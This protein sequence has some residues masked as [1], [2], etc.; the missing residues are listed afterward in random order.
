MLWDLE[1]V[2]RL[3]TI[4]ESFGFMCDLSEEERRMLGNPEL[5][6]VII[7][8]T[9][10]VMFEDRKMKISTYSSLQKREAVFFAFQDENIDLDRE[11]LKR[12]PLQRIVGMEFGI[13]ETIL[14]AYKESRN[15][16]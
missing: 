9:F 1:I 16:I 14:K 13:F 12:V 8:P 2:R 11:D 15:E 10:A 5:P 4:L 7:I 6:D 3:K